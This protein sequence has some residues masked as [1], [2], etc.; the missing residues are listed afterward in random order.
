MHLRSARARGIRKMHVPLLQPWVGFV[1]AHGRRIVLSLNGGFLKG[2]V[3]YV[4]LAP[5]NP[6]LGGF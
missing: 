1:L 6:L 5:V 2:T 4:F 3:T